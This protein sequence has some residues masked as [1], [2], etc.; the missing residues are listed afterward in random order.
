MKKTISI[1]VLCI[2]I[3]FLLTMLA[4]C[5]N[6]DTTKENKIALTLD[7][8]KNYIDI[9][10]TF[11]GDPSEIYWNNLNSEYRY[12]AVKSE[13]TITSVAPY[14]KFENCS[15]KIKIEGQYYYTAT[16][17]STYSHDHTVALSMGGTGSSSYS[18]KQSN[19]H[20]IKGRGYTVLS[21]SG[22]VI[23]E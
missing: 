8:Y 10:C 11:A 2:T 14:L 7:N 13:V 9:K 17:K 6:K 12:N 5:P 20:D 15:V 21:V 3:I 22:Y 4:G 23:V 18:Y 1:I 16:A 19:C